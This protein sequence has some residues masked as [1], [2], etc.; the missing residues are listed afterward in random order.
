M[1]KE[2]PMFLLQRE[3]AVINAEKPGISH[4]STKTVDQQEASRAA[5]ERA[6]G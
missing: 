3:E 5:Q 6:H 4:E 2:D 1:K